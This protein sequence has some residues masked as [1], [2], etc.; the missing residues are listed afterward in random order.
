MPSPTAY[1]FCA[2]ARSCRS[3]DAGMSWVGALENR[4][5]SGALGPAFTPP[6]SRTSRRKAILVL[7][8][9]RVG[10]SPPA[11]S[12]RSAEPAIVRAFRREWRP[13]APAAVVRRPVMVLAA[14]RARKIESGIS[15]TPT[16]IAFTATSS[17]N[18]RHALTTATR[19]PC[20]LLDLVE[21]GVQRAQRDAGCLRSLRSDGSHCRALLPASTA[22]ATQVSG[23][24]KPRW[25]V[26]RHPP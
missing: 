9:R 26:T 16:A 25:R 23:P 21:V 4:G 22:A 15:T 10:L 1:G 13:G 7:V 5:G 24:K 19:Y 12:S 6:G 17:T 14:N 3:V 11:C 8:R 2:I 18:A 20:R